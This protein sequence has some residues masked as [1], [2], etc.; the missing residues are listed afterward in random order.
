MVPEN[1]I[2][3]KNPVNPSANVTTEWYL[4]PGVFDICRQS[5]CQKS[6]GP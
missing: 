2:A 3:I 1:G 4:D 6:P 5:L